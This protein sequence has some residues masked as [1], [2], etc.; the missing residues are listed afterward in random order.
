MGEASTSLAGQ[1]S[2]RHARSPQKLTAYFYLNASH[3]F[4][5]VFFKLA[6]FITCLFFTC[7][8]QQSYAQQPIVNEN[9]EVPGGQFK[10]NWKSRF[11]WREREKIKTW[12]TQAANT[13]SLV[14]G[15][16]PLRTTRININRTVKGRSAVPWAHTL[17]E[18]TPEGVEFHVNPNATL[19]SFV[20]DWTAV[21][22]FSHLYIPYPGS[23]DVWIS[24]GFASYYQNILMARGK[25]LSGKQ[26]WQK[27]ADG[28]HRGSRDQ[29]NNIKLHKLSAGRSGGTMRVYWS[30][31][32]YFLEA[33]LNL[34]NTGQSL[35]EVINEYV[36]CCRTSR[37][38][39]NGS[40]LATEF[41][42]IAGREIFHPL[43]NKY[44][45][46]YSFRDYKKVLARLGIT[47]D[48][49]HKVL[50]EMDDYHSALRA[51]FVSPASQVFYMTNED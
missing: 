29:K 40:I 33:D 46:E 7:L 50:L 17:R 28:F 42:R 10:I 49:R 35:D 45:N 22:E 48:A 32:L 9:L 21:H 16:F 44:A 12:L 36:K 37:K 20:K 41:D 13:A 14:N 47:L 3:L 6:L 4:M 15:R 39:T 38:Y 11:D 19:A 43:Y 5:P 18:S 1:R 25:I 2:W 24:E 23:R 26:A 51:S 31:A 27:L 30:G 34:R 8:G